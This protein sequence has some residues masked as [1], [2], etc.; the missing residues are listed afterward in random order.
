MIKYTKPI[1]EV[2]ESIESLE[3]KID[4][5]I[6]EI[7]IDRVYQNLPSNISKVEIA[8]VLNSF[9]KK[10]RTW[11]CLKD[12]F[13]LPRFLLN[14]KLIK[15]PAPTIRAIENKLF[16]SNLECYVDEIIK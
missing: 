4:P 1:D 10:M 8:L 15:K 12:N 5:K 6:A 2:K 3:C 14:I 13:E 16:S 7:L 11:T 9:V